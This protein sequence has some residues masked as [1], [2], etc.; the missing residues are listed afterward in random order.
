MI[1]EISDSQIQVLF[2]L[3]RAAKAT[4]PNFDFKNPIDVSNEV[5]EANREDLE[6]LIQDGYLERY[7]YS[8]PR[9]DEQVTVTSQHAVVL[10][11]KGLR[12]A[13]KGSEA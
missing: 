5:L 1:R 8:S 13:A 4:D 12:I 10:T 11:E 9:R 3:Y 7:Q 6:T 2:G